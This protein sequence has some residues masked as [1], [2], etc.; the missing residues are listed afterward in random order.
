[1]YQTD[2][3]LLG[4]FLLLHD[5][6]SLLSLPC[7]RGPGEGELGRSR[8][9]LPLLFLSMSCLQ[10]HDAPLEHFPFATHCLH[11]P[12]IPSLFLL[13]SSAFLLMGDSTR[14]PVLSGIE[15]SILRYLIQACT[16]LILLYR[17]LIAQYKCGLQQL[18]I[19]EF[20]F[21][22]TFQ[23]VILGSFPHG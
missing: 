3:C 9:P 20:C 15:V 18:R 8:L 22:H 13:L 11:P 14:C 10:L 5:F 19:T 23:C 16:L 7:D 17:I 1:M 21:V 12:V 4:L 2:W 6:S